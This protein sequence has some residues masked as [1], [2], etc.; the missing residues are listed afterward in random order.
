MFDEILKTVKEHFADNPHLTADVP[1]DQHDALH[2]E[3]AEHVTNNLSSAAPGAT[4]VQSE[5][6][7]ALSLPGGL[8]GI[9]DKLKDSLTAGGPVVSAIEGGLVGSLASKFGLNP[10]I[11]GAIAAA[12]PGLLQKFASKQAAGADTIPATT[13]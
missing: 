10:A 1:A 13:H 12:L 2:N 3:I 4:M 5:A 9:L 6:Q 8:G 11:S 7:G